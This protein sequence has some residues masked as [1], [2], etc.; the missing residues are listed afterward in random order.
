MLRT[1]LLRASSSRALARQVANRPLSRDIVARF[2]AGESVSEGLDAAAELARRGMSVTLDHVGEHVENDDQARAAAEVYHRLLGSEAVATGTVSISVKPTQLG[3]LL[4]AELCQALVGDLAAH[5]AGSGVHVTL[6]MEDH[7]VTEATVAMA[8]RAHRDG[9]P[10]VAVA[11]QAAL[12]R[13]PEDVRRLT[14]VGASIRLCKGAYAEPVHLAHTDRAAVDRSYLDAAHFLLEHAAE[15]RF[16]THDHRL[17]AAI[18]RRAAEIGR[19]PGTYEF[20]LLYGVREDMQ[21]ALV[22]DGHRVRVYVPFGAEWFPYF[23]RR[24]AERPANLALL[25]RALTDTGAR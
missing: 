18:R 21:R 24:L 12:H 11:L 3:L 9:Y 14:A 8:E 25:V 17:V 5:A 7:T 23:T 1:L 13:T 4:D 10:N 15:P 19:L 22:G 16:A 2:V 6:D 20:Q